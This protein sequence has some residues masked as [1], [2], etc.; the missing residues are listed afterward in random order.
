MTECPVGHYGDSCLSNCS[1]NC[2]G[3]CDMITGYCKQCKEGWAGNK[4][5]VG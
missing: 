4:C 5:E 1:V 3:T 2:D